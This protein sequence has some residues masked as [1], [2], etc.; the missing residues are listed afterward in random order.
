M[1]EA[2]EALAHELESDDPRERSRA[3]LF[4]GNY[5]AHA[6]CLLPRLLEMVSLNPVTDS[7]GTSCGEFVSVGRILRSIEDLKKQELATVEMVRLA[8]H[9][10]SAILS[11]LD[12]A[13]G[14][15]ASL[16]IHTL[17][18]T[19]PRTAHAASVVSRVAAQSED[20]RMKYRAYQFACSVCPELTSIPPWSDFAPADAEDRVKW[21]AL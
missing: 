5:G 2:V 10:I 14:A 13:T 12:T 7:A 18:L 6:I 8:D 15:R 11:H 16:L 3:A 17:A 20:Q 19:G 9:C 1:N 21:G 4:A